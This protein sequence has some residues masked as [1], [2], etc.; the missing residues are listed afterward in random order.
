ML[1]KIFGKRND[2]LSEA[3]MSHNPFKPIDPKLVE[4]HDKVMAYRVTDDEWNRAFTVPDDVPPQMPDDWWPDRFFVQME[5]GPLGAEESFLSIRGG[6]CGGATMATQRY[7]YI[8]G[9]IENMRRACWQALEDRRL[10][11]ERYAPVEN[12]AWPGHKL[13]ALT[14]TCRRCGATRK[15]FDD[16]LP[17]RECTGAHDWHK[18]ML[19]EALY[20][21]NQ[22]RAELAQTR[23]VIRVMTDV[24]QFA[25]APVGLRKVATLPAW[26]KSDLNRVR[27]GAPEKIDGYGGAII[28]D[29]PHAPEDD[30]PERREAVKAWFTSRAETI[31]EPAGK[32]V[33]TPIPVSDSVTDAYKAIGD[34]LAKDKRKVA[35][36]SAAQK[37]EREKEASKAIGR[38]F[39]LGALGNLRRGGGY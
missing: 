19:G 3:S 5:H 2:I 26:L 18:N 15:D 29:D 14:G 17:P 34:D 25:S 33:L 37:V 22:L 38:A 36:D 31:E 16:H 11:P 6:H 8:R 4:L 30:T 32:D 23:A 10:R 28:M 7:D 27:D 13:D 9:T 1:P 21:R 24:M 12:P 39:D 35:D 20:E